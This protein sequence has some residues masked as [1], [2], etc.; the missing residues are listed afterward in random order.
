MTTQQQTTQT[1]D[2]VVVGGGAAGLS[3]ALVLGRAR[4]S[5]LVVD[6]GEP[7]NAPAGQVHGYLGH[8][9]TPPVE[10]LATAREEVARYGVQVEQATVSDA[11]PAEGGGFDVRVGGRT[12]G[13]TVTARRVLLATGL[14][15]VLPD[16]P[17]VAQGWGRSILHCP[18]CHGWEVRDTALAVLATGPLSVH[19]AL[20]FRQWTD[21]LVLLQHTAPPLTQEQAAQLAARGV[22]VVPGRVVAWEDS[23]ARLEDGTLVPRTGL[24]VAPFF[25]ARTTLLASL[26]VP[27]RELDMGGVVA[28]THAEADAR[29]RTPVPGVWVAGNAADLGAQVITSAAGGLTAAAA[30]NADLVEEDTAL[31]VRQAELLSEQAWDERYAAG[32]GDGWSGGP[33]AVLVQ[34]ATGLRPG[35]ALDVGAGEGGDALWLAAQGWEVTGSDV[36]SVVLEKAAAVAR[37]RGLQVTWQHADAREQAPPAGAYDLV[38]AFFVHPA[39]DARRALDRRL[40]DAV[41]PGGSLLLAAHAPS[42]VHTGM[43]DPPLLQLFVTPEQ[44]LA[45]L[46]LDAFEVLVAEELPRAEARDGVHHHVSDV[47]VHVRRRA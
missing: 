25:A 9:G 26:G 44:V 22:R 19:Q 45:D 3:A 4:R 11:R 12:V 43:G 23:G 5:V 15:D 40:A 34:E 7:R 35:R 41:A 2:V 46:D 28:G 36:S 29:G 33:N 39:A 24:V 37:E 21:D 10:L 18:Y 6:A 14:V 8:E 42:H 16:V 30:I 20:L 17:G 31:A 27:V 1:Y 13:R 38:T 47:V 32:A